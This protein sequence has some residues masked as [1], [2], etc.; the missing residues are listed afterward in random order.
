V[1]GV[2][3][4]FKVSPARVQVGEAVRFTFRLINNAGQ[5]ALLEFPTGQRYDFWATRNEGE[6]WRWSKGRVFVQQITRATIEPQSGL[7]F[8][9]TWTPELAGTYAVH[10][11]LRANGYGGELTGELIVE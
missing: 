4:T 6:T 10:G 3:V 2:T 7:N 5:D 1:G 8:A 9:E 11:E